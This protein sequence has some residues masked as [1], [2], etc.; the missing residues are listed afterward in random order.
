M[1]TRKSDVNTASLEEKLLTLESEKILWTKRA[2]TVGKAIERLMNGLHTDC[3]NAVHRIL[4][5]PSKD[6]FEFCATWA[7]FGQKDF[8][9]APVLNIGPVCKA[10]MTPLG[11]AALVCY[12]RAWQELAQAHAGAVEREINLL[13]AGPAEPA[14]AAKRRKGS[15]SRSRVAADTRRKDAPRGGG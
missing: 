3:S 5:E 12:S 9:R 1:T 14:Q 6:E 8:E 15:R 13:R 4:T 7:G 10:T 11:I 2:E